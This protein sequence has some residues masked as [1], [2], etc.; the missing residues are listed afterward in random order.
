MDRYFAFTHCIIA[1]EFSSSGWLLEFFLG[2]GFAT[3]N[4]RVPFFLFCHFSLV[5]EFLC[6]MLTWTGLSAL[7]R[8]ANF[9]AFFSFAPQLSK[10]ENNSEGQTQKFFRIFFV[11]GFI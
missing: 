9:K 2:A 5:Q 1:T 7:K 8:T 6:F 11:R 4:Q 10:M 3:N